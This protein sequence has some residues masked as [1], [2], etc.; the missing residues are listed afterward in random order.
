[1]SGLPRRRTCLGS[2]ASFAADSG[3]FATPAG[4]SSSA[5]TGPLR[6]QLVDVP[7]ADR[8]HDRVGQ[9]DQRKRQ[10][11]SLGLDR[12]DRIGGAQD[13]P[14]EP[15]LAADL[16]DDPS[17][18]SAMKPS[19][20]ACT[21]GR[22]YQP[23][24]NSRP[25]LQ[26]HA[27]T[28]P[29]AI[30]SDADADHDAES[31]RRPA[32]PAAAASRGK[33]LRP[34]NV[35]CRSWVMMRLPRLGIDDLGDVAL[36]L[37]VG[38]REQDEAGRMRSVPVRFHRGDLRRLMLRRVQPVQVADESCSGA[39]IATMPRPIR[40]IVRASSWNRFAST[41]A[42]AHRQHHERRREVARGQHVQR[43]DTGKLGLKMT[44][45]QSTG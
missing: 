45:S 5:C 35:P 22:R 33:S 14:G 34:L 40:I 24:S 6:D 20:H 12:R 1:M 36:V 30:I 2:P 29:I 31:D 26:S 3:R 21:T 11:D 7:D 4:G 32:P 38:P 23:W 10:R 17:G 37:R 13:A 25:R 39:R 16:G 19:G 43:S 15:G 8:E 9:D 27:P 42:R 18:S 41:V 28:K 44:A